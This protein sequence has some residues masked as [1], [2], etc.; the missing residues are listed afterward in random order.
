MKRILLAGLFGSLFLLVLPTPAAAQ[1]GIPGQYL[2]ADGTCQCPEGYYH[3]RSTV[4]CEQVEC[5][6]GAGRTYTLECACPEG[7]VAE[8]TPLTTET[9]RFTYQRAKINLDPQVYEDISQTG[10]RSGPTSPK[11]PA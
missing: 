2:A 6:E 11:T 9:G 8:T 10:C 1:C 4:A 7:T 5:P 3:D